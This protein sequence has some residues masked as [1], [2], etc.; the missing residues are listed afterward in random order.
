MDVQD[1]VK[2][3]NAKLDTVLNILRGSHDATGKFTPGLSHRVDLV[4]VRVTTLEKDSERAE[5][6]RLTVARGA[7]L[8]LFGGLVSQFLGWIRDHAR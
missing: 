4:E 7:G 2:A 6:G 5:D 1:E 8:A 3:I